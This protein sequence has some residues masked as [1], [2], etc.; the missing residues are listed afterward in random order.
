MVEAESEEW[1]LEQQLAEAQ[2]PTPAPFKASRIDEPMGR[3]DEDKTID[4]LSPT[5]DTVSALGN[6]VVVDRRRLFSE[7]AIEKKEVY[8]NDSFHSADEWQGD[9]KHVDSTEASAD[10]TESTESSKNDETDDTESILS[11]TEKTESMQAEDEELEDNE[12]ILNDTENTESM[13][14]K[15][16]EL[17]DTQSIDLE[18]DD[19]Q[20]NLPSEIPEDDFSKLQLLVSMGYEGGMAMN[21]LVACD[22]DFHKALDQ[23]CGEHEAAGTAVLVAEHR[24]TPD[25]GVR[26]QKVRF[27]HGTFCENPYLIF[28]SRLVERISS[29]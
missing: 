22:M 21:A 26:Q 4:S 2:A 18:P 10:E 8:D 29:W 17:E 25:R 14:A 9:T 13:Q 27:L 7:S 20:S 6:I 5:A 23:L 1:N 15:D 3:L 28:L 19:A 11:D 16:E 24:S 12:S